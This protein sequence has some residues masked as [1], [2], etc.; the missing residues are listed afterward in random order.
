MYSSSDILSAIERGSITI[1]D[2]D[3][4]RLGPNSYDLLLGK[5]FF[6]VIWDEDGPWF[7]G[8]S[9]YGPQDRVNVPVGGTLLAMTEDVIGTFGK[10]TGKLYARSTWGRAGITV[11]RDAGLGD[12]GYCNHWTLEMTGH[13]TSGQPFVTVGERIAQITFLETIRPPIK[14]YLG[15][16]N[17]DDWPLCMV[18]KMW[19]H[20]IL[21]TFSQNTQHEIS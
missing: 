15:Q 21:D 18:P 6:D 2:F 13:V 8:P 7:V 20:R 19:R 9:E 16:Y 11:C 10:V 3:E 4:S 5:F 14:A 12:I 1:S 17:A